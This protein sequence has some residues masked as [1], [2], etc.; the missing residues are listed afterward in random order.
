[1]ALTPHEGSP[2]PGVVV[3]VSCIVTDPVASPSVAHWD[4][5]SL[6]GSVAIW[7]E[8]GRPL[9]G[10]DEYLFRGNAIPSDTAPPGRITGIPDG[11]GER[12]TDI[13]VSSGIV[14]VHANP[15]G[16]TVVAL[17]YSSRL[18]TVSPGFP[19]ID[20]VAVLSPPPIR[21]TCA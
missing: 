7:Y 12:I 15:C 4:V 5:G 6:L 3:I 21:S 2:V 18:I 11:I 20:I 14:G 1:M 19:S 10:V 13:S 17:G 16:H 8:Y 9:F